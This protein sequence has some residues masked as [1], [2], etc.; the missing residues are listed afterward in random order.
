[1][2]NGDG[3][4]LKTFSMFVVEVETFRDKFDE[5]FRSV[6]MHNF[7]FFV[8]NERR[9]ERTFFSCLNCLD[10][11]ATYSYCIMVLEQANIL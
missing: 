5:M 3:C 8:W 1:M 10:V 6:G 4:I 9:R 2:E 7:V 11:E